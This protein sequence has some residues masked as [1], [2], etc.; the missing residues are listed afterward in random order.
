M[1]HQHAEST[2]C[3]FLY[4]STIR[5]DRW[6]GQ[7]T[8]LEPILNTLVIGHHEWPDPPTLNQVDLPALS[9]LQRRLGGRVT[10][11]CTGRVADTQRFLVG[12]LRIV[13]IP[14]KYGAPVFCWRSVLLA[15]CLARESDEAL[16]IVASDV[17]G[18]FVG[19]AMKRARGAAFVMNVQGDVLDPGREYGSRLKREL[20]RRAVRLIIRRADA[21]RSLNTAIAS[22]VRAV[23]PT[24]TNVVIESR[25]DTARFAYRGS[26]RLVPD[27]GPR[28]LCVGAL[29]VLKN[30]A[31]LI[32]AVGLAR[33]RAPNIRLVLVGA[34][35]HEQSLRE[36]AEK[37]GVAD[38]VEF[39]GRVPYADLPSLLAAAD[40][41][42]FP[43]LS[44]GRPRAVLEAQSVGVP[45]VASDIPAHREFITHKLSGLLLSPTEPSSWAEA[46]VRLS[47]DEAL[48]KTMS[49]H[50][51]SLVESQYEFESQLDLIAALIRDT[52]EATIR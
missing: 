42:A 17:W 10:V 41:F 49:A 29:T 30:Q 43:S 35:P 23:N 25:V 4:L 31:L 18:G 8:Y 44:E 28:V 5:S 45:V 33:K 52:V 16:T 13:L 37:T 15:Y 51:R 46:I 34:G 20:L 9:G 26:H 22:Q 19:S 32:R 27:E 14:A 24:V 11:I 3:G 12:D 1:V 21:V 47:G 6:N 48:R 50:A 36:L 7:A 2:P 39:L 38:A 40:V